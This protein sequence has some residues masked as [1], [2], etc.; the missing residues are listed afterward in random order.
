M[1]SSRWIPGLMIS[2][3]LVSLCRADVIVTTP[4]PYDKPPAP[5]VEKGTYAFNG[6][7]YAGPDCFTTII[8]AAKF[9]PDGSGKGGSLCVKANITF[10]GAGPVCTSEIASGQQKQLFVLDGPYYYNHDGTL[11]E[12]VAIV[13]GAFNGQSLTF[14]DYVSPDGKLIFLTGAPI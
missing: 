4:Y 13:G 14:H 11:C 1:K 6:S 10:D 8:G 9:L 2:L 5:G 12:N 7:G 3:L